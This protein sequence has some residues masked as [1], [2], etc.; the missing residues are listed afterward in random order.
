MKE[1]TRFDI[2]GCKIAVE[3]AKLL[4][5]LIEMNLLLWIERFGVGAYSFYANISFEGGDL[6]QANFQQKVDL[7]WLIMLK[8]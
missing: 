4:R 3:Y 2:T 5:K 1:I 6:D 7:K 8:K